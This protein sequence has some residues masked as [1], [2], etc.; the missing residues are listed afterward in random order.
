MGM[1]E[2]GPQPVAREEAAEFVRDARI[3][4]HDAVPARIQR[5]DRLTEY[6]S[7]ACR[8]DAATTL[9]AVDDGG[10]RRLARQCAEAA[11]E[12]P[13]R[14]EIS[15][16]PAHFG[17]RYIERLCTKI[18]HCRAILKRRVTLGTADAPTAADPF[19]GPAL[20]RP[21]RIMQRTPC[22]AAR[23]CVL[24]H[25]TGVGED[26]RR[27]AD[28]GCALRHTLGSVVGILRRRAALFSHV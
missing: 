17:R 20:A 10:I 11:A 25:R 28:D 5:L 14:R 4:H 23:N 19:H 7:G 3:D 27:H 2:N 6:D 12:A 18:T 13:A 1:F 21:R 16:E 24:Y 22:F 15:V 8:F 26:L 9:C